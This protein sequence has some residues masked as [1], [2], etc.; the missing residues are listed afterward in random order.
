MEP[1]GI[2]VRRMSG[3]ARPQR[4]VEYS[5]VK[6][7]EVEWPHWAVMGATMDQKDVETSLL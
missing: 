2:L 5:S 3:V 6:G 4:M 1:V 7:C